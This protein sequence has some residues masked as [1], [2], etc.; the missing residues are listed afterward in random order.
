L[1]NVR[2][3]PIADIPL[4][5]HQRRVKRILLPLLMLSLTSCRSE[6]DE[7]VDGKS[8]VRLAD[9]DPSRATQDAA[10]AFQKGDRRLLGVYGFTTSVPGGEGSTLPVRMI[11]ETTDAVDTE[12]CEKR[13]QRAFEYAAAYNR[14]M[15]AKA[16]A[17]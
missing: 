13:N 2:F 3:P 12:D 15:I 1:L 9:L 14:W 5:R 10:T 11:E 7:A 4:L 8:C 17:P 6:K 16:S